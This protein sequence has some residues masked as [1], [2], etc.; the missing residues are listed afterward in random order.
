[1][2][3]EKMT[4]PNSAP[5][6]VSDYENQNLHLAGVMTGYVQLSLTNWNTT[7]LPAI[8][9]GG[10]VEVGGTFY[11]FA[12]E[13][14]ISGSPSA[15]TVYVKL[16]CSG[17]DCTPTWA[18]TAPSWDAAK[19]GWYDSSDRYVFLAYYDYYGANYIQKAP[20]DR[21]MIESP[22]LTS[23]F[24]TAINGGGLING[25]FEHA[26][27][28]STAPFGWLLGLYAGGTSGFYTTSPAQGSQSY[29][30]VHP[31]GASNGGGFIVSD[32]I[33]C[34]PL[35]DIEVSGIYW[36]TVA[37]MKN[38][39]TLYWFDE[40]KAALAGAEKYTRLYDSISNPTSATAGEWQA[41]P[42][43]TARF[44]H[45][46]L[47]GGYTDTDVAA[48]AYFDGFEVKRKRQYRAGDLLLCYA[49]DE[50]VTSS[51]TDVKVKEFQV[52]RSGTLRVK[53]DM[54]SQHTGY[55]D[56]ARAWIAI[57]DA[58]VSGT[59]HTRDNTA[60][61]TYSHD[62]EDLEPGDKLQLWVDCEDILND[63]YVRNFR[64]YADCYDYSPLITL[65]LTGGP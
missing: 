25:S 13:T 6:A 52:L 8:A 38:M 26:W 12:S 59:R 34:S 40:D 49:D 37:G 24:A 5:T 65:D 43:A 64:I 30:F 20:I 18:N 54:R 39:V 46:H 28:N 32:S 10:Y 45:L 3:D 36:A 19:N 63:T 53:F 42:P 57:N 14:A 7:A 4:F 44:C 11:K 15:G 29:Y 9:A 1:M 2:A 22:A 58:E 16:V 31:G 60:F 55:G 21:F 17:D 47:A 23:D 41:R 27:L 33:P 62:I 51:T 56:D 50:Y 48:T 61:T 35:F